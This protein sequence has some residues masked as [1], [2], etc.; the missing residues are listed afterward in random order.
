LI[1]QCTYRNHRVPTVLDFGASHINFDYAFFRGLAALERGDR[2]AALDHFRKANQYVWGIREAPNNIG[3]A[4]AEHGMTDEAAAY[5]RMAADIDPRYLTPR[6]N[7]F[8]IA[9]VR[10]DWAY[11]RSILQ[12]LIDAAPE[13]YRSYAEMGFLLRDRFGDIES[14][15]AYWRR[16]LRINPD[17]PEVVKAIA[18][19]GRA[20][21]R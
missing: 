13:N 2:L 21:S 20:H 18:E 4:L 19:G 17:Q 16:S 11:A 8:R 9:E 1:E 3:S 12:E 14:A 7:L 6:W 5:F 15:M 10:A